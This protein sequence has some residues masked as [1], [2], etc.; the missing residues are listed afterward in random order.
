MS[1]GSFD[2]AYMRV[3]QFADE[4]ELMLARQDKVND[5]GEKPYFIKEV[6]RAKL[7]EIEETV[8]VAALLM[9]EVEWLYSGDTSEDTFMKQVDEIQSRK[10]E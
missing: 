3:Q 7:L 8:R 10:E 2:Y 9:K 4:L 1:G 5:W 6:T